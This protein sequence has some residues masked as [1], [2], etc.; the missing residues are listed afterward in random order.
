M[1]KLLAAGGGMMLAIMILSNN[2]MV[3][4]LGNEP[5]VVINHIVGLITISIIL[6]MTKERR[7][8]MKGIPL[9][10]LLGGVTGVGTVFFTNASYIALGA[11]ITLMLSMIGRI[12]TSTVIDHYGLMS[13]PRY[14]FNRRKAIGLLLMAVGLYCIMM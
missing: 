7:R 6:L 14:P 9:F 10:Y 1:Y 4:A 2:M 8:S 3:L 11:T 12:V 13:R 5:A